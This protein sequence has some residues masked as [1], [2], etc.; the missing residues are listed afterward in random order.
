ML[1]RGYTWPV[2]TAALPLD[3]T[4]KT[5][6]A[7]MKTLTSLAATIAQNPR[8]TLVPEVDVPPHSGKKALA[9]LRR[10]KHDPNA[11]EILGPIGEGGMGVVSLGR[12]VAL[13]RKVAI[14]T[15]R[16]GHCH[17]EN[18]ES[19][20]GEAWLAGSLE[21]PNIVPIYDLGLDEAGAPQLVMKRIEGETWSDLLA[22]DEAARRHALGRDPLEF[23]LSVLIQVCNAVHY[24]HSREVVHRDLKPENVMVGHFG[25]VYVLDWGVA[26]RPGPVQHVAGTLVYMAPEMLGGLGDLS[27]RTDV[28]LLGAVLY[29]VLSGKAPHEGNSMQSMVSSIVLSSPRLPDDAPAELSALVTAC[30]HRDPAHRPESAFDV[31]RAL[32]RFLE[33]RGAMAIAAQAEAKLADL[34]ALLAE[35]TEK[36]DL[37]RVY[38]VFGEC[39]FGFRQALRAWPENESAREGLRRAISDMVRFEVDQG[40]ARAAAL[41]LTELEEPDPELDALV[42]GVRKKAGEEAERIEKLKKMEKE[43]DPREGR[44]GRL[45]SGVI[46]GG[47]WTILP[48]F[49][50]H[51]VRVH[52]EWE[53]LASVPFAILS[54][55]LLLVGQRITRVAAKLNRQLMNAF[56]FSLAAQ[57]IVTL[58]ILFVA[59]IDPRYFVVTMDAYWFVVMGMMAAAIEWRLL[60]LPLAYATAFYLALRFPEY[61]YDTI[62]GANFVALVTVA[63]IW[64]AH[65]TEHEIERQK[66]RAERGPGCKL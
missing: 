27:A 64:S 39:R 66:R 42:E 40:D 13:G 56:V 44:R 54:V 14:K 51:L 24:A 35:S 7:R 62:T 45:A 11:L 28:Y 25:E 2:T 20:L 23:H 15:L 37:I 59:H 61:R 46:M 5:I 19:L 26:T 60:P 29:E 38:N 55:V 6:Q 33:H 48:L 22:D 18:I 41:L 30:M 57:P 8:Q 17:L 1:K 32:E 47:L 49:A 34:E 16:D 36:P 31:R 43:L 12:Q 21:H 65:A 9:E 3:D 63:L 50:P 4:D 58:T 10:L 53:G 52:P